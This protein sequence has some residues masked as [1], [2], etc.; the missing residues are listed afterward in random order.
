V[1]RALRRAVRDAR[2]GLSRGAMAAV[3]PVRRTPVTVLAMAAVAWALLVGATPL[4]ARGAAG[5]GPAYAA[6]VVRTAAAPICHQ[7][8]ERSF[9]WGDHTFPVCG[10]CL[11]LYLSGATAL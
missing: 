4:L 10:R 7:R 3:G 2:A 11:S 5:S 9:A 1:P 6:T 8:P